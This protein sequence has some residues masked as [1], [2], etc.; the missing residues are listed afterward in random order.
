MARTDRRLSMR[1]VGLGLGATAV[2]MAMMTA[3]VA[4]SSPGRSGARSLDRSDAPTGTVAAPTVASSITGLTLIK[5][6]F[7]KPLLVTHAY[8]TRLFVVEQG[9]KIKVLKPSSSGWHVPATP[10]LDISGSLPDPLGGDQGLL[11]LAFHPQYASNGRF[12]VYYTN[13]Y[14]DNIIAEFHRNA[15]DP[16]RADSARRQLLKIWHTPPGTQHNGG[17]MAF[18]PTDG[19]LYISTGDGNGTNPPDAAGNAQDPAS[20]LGKILRID[21]NPTTGYATPADNPYVGVPGA[22]GEVW[23]VGLRNPWRWSFDR[24]T[25]KLWIGDVG[26]KTYEEVSRSATGRGVNFGWR[27]YEGRHQTIVDGTPLCAADAL[28]DRW[29]PVIEYSHGSTRCSVT[30]GYVY[31]GTKYPSLVGRY[32][33][34]DFCSG[35]M[36]NIAANATNPATLPT[37]FATGINPSSFGEGYTGELYVVDLYSPGGVYRVTGN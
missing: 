12:F 31:R 32:I 24:G 10:F 19:Y 11:G 4:A 13:R 9:G 5:D 34:A 21:V 25:G 27:C 7:T 3:P 30:G 33:W 8:D 29:S 28:P 2:A 23:S 17:M 6:G 22:R 36:W 14:G 1:R 16:D 20:I 37:P 26:Y 35:E 15:T 18:G